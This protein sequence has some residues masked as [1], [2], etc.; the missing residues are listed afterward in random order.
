MISSIKLWLVDNAIFERVLSCMIYKGT[1]GDSART[2]DR[3]ASPNV[4][5][6]LVYCQAKGRDN[7]TSNINERETSQ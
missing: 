7:L 1:L 5:S 2:F 3:F 6:I 4:P